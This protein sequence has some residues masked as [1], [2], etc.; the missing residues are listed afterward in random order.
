MAE[1][2]LGLLPLYLQLYRNV[3]PAYDPIVVKFAETIA[4]TI[5]E[6]GADVVLAPVCARADEIGPA[7]TKFE[8]SNVDAIVT[9]HLAYSPSL[10]AIDALAKTRLPVMMLD[11]TPDFGYPVDHTTLM[12]NHG[13]HGVQDLANRLRRAGK[14][15]K[16]FVGHWENSNVIQ[17]LLESAEAAKCANAFMHSRVGRIGGDFKGMGDFV[18]SDEAMKRLGIEC[19]NMDMKDYKVDESRLK[20]VIDE[21]N[22]IK[23]METADRETLVRASAIASLMVRDFI[24]KEKLTAFTCSFLD[25]CDSGVPTIPF[26]EACLAMSRGIGYAGEGDAMDAAW[27]GAILK[28]I[29]DTTFT[30]MFCPDWKTGRVYLSHMGEVNAALLQ[31]PALC[32]QKGKYLHDPKPLAFTGSLRPGQAAIVNL[33]PGP[34]DIP[35][36]ITIRGEIT[37]FPENDNKRI[38]AWFRPVT[39]F[40]DFLRKYS[41]CGG[42]HHSAL[43]YDVKD[44]FWDDLASFLGIKHHII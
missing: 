22:A 29:K 16:V 7:V 11:T 44:S 40:C 23:N 4:A 35:E 15:Y 42:T 1:L 19:V 26:V 13:I 20:P 5:K 12:A 8:A 28:V 38:S 25:A 2:K 34:G 30:E 3:A 32:M 21:L 17:K 27:V 9:L 33:A 31:N 14:P 41:E 10:E 18:I 36:L 6:A 43:C 37:P 39:P 24:E